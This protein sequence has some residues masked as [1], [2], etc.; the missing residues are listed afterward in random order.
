MPAPPLTL[1]QPNGHPTHP[2][3]A[4]PGWQRTYQVSH[5]V[6]ENGQFQHV[7][8]Q[9]ELR[10]L[11][12]KGGIRSYSLAK[13]HYRLNGEEP[14]NALDLLHIATAAVLYP[15][16]MDAHP[17]KGW[18]GLRNYT[19][20]L[21]R[22]PGVKE[23]QMQLYSG[24]WMDSYLQSLEGCLFD[25][26][27]LE[28]ALQEDLALLVLGLPLY[29]KNGTKEPLLIPRLVSPQGLPVALELRWDPQALTATASIEWRG[30]AVPDSL[31]QQAR[32]ELSGGE[33]ETALRVVT[34][35]QGQLEAD[36]L[37]GHV[38]SA[39]LELEVVS[40]GYHQHT[41][42]EMSTLEDFGHY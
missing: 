3:D 14:E 11:A 24:E 42:L 41:Q 1:S 32:S 6:G 19:D 17:R 16:E 9:L 34:R 38:R 28:Q 29:G 13:S 40:E 8:Y 10:L 35:L 30:V 12:R 36:P 18:Q 15:L 33:P 37:T 26:L 20:L 23:Q 39:H 27:G 2:A 7:Q 31:G 5:R 22:W 21:A 25:P 4:L